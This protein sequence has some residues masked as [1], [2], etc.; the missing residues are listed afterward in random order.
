MRPRQ[1]F[2]DGGFYFLIAFVIVSAI[3]CYVVRGA[4]AFWLTLEEHLWLLLALAPVVVGSVLLAAGLQVLMHPEFIRKHLGEGS[5]LKGLLKATIIGMM[6]PGGPM[7]SLPLLTAVMGAGANAMAGVAF[8]VSWS[9]LPVS[10]IVQWEL[11][12]MG[13]DFTMIR[14]LASV[15]LPVLAAWM[16]A[17]VL[18][19]L[20]PGGIW[21][22]DR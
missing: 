16:A 10:R 5:G 3:G 20:L 19:R 18:R 15:P 6:V 14:Y 8:V 9:V 7:V 17:P 13:G 11:P 1:R 12:L 4:D 22:K 21:T 2:F